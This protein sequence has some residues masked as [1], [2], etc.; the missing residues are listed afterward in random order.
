MA[1]IFAQERI[2]HTQHR[3]K[4][5]CY[6]KH[7]RFYFCDRLFLSVQLFKEI[8]LRRCDFSS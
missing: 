4:T 8:F 2:R 7:K 6:L 3:R 1:P 5:E